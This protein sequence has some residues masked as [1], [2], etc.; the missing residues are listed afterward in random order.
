MRALQA[1]I[2]ATLSSRLERKA[3]ELPKLSTLRICIAQIAVVG[4]ALDQMTKIWA[5]RNLDPANPPSYLGGFLKFR[6]LFNPGAAFSLGTQFTVGLTI[7]ALVAL[8]GVI[9]WLAPRVRSW[10]MVVVCGLLIAGIS[11]NLIDRLFRPP[12]PF[13]GHVVDFIS[14]PH[15]AIFNVADICITGA[16]AIFLI[17]V[18]LTPDEKLDPAR[19]SAK[20][21]R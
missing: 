16:A 15:F 5:I 4:L 2:G 20:D 8:A 6:L 12:A 3:D 14:L 18:L 11:G 9:G 17:Y 21:D 13:R 1:T 10:T 7:F 19:S